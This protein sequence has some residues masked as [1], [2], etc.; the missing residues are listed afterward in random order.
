MKNN[1]TNLTD[2]HINEYIDYLTTQKILQHFK[3]I[4][5]VP[6]HKIQYWRKLK[7]PVLEATYGT[8]NHPI[9]RVV[10][11]FEFVE[12]GYF[13]EWIHIKKNPL[14]KFN[15]VCNILAYK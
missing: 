4:Y 7:F 1:Y 3:P 15:S 5:E 2:E 12:Q 14:W 10:G 6:K 8:Y 11:I 9:L 13:E